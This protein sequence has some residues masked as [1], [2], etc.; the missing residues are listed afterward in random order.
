MTFSATLPKTGLFRSMA[1]WPRPW[2]VMTTISAFSA[3]IA[4]RI[5]LAADAQTQA[6]RLM[7]TAAA[8]DKKAQELEAQGQ[9]EASK[10]SY[11]QS[12]DVYNRAQGLYVRSALYALRNQQ[13]LFRFLAP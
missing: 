8:Q 12:K 2:V 11:R 7:E 4:L 6:D 9:E 3:S 10:A 5:S 13:M 1:S